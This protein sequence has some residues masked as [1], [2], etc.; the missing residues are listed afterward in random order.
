MIPLNRSSGQSY[1][2]KQRMRVIALGLATL[3]AIGLLLLIV[4]FGEINP[5]TITVLIVVI[6]L[7][8]MLATLILAANNQIAQDKPKRG[9]AGQDMYSLI[10][11]MVE[12]LDEDEAAYLQRRLDE[13]E[14]KTKND[15]AVSLEELLDHRAQARP[16]QQ[17]ETK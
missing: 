17:D 4:Q 5:G 9:L 3:C 8:V 16:S 11:R 10:D 2:Q 12:E 14:N 7:I 15:L 1:P 13:R 6:G